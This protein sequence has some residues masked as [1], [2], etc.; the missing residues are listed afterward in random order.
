ML[1]TDGAEVGHHYVYWCDSM[2][3]V[4]QQVLYNQ[5]L[6]CLTCLIKHTL[7]IW[8]PNEK[9]LN[10]EILGQGLPI[11]NYS[12]YFFYFFVFNLIWSF[13]SLALGTGTPG[14]TFSG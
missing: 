14:W 3:W 2:E 8:V 4:H 5:N 13:K 7:Y 1:T 6:T 9:C 12:K 10:Q 11:G